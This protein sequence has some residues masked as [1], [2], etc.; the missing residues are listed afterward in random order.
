METIRTFSKK[1]RKNMTDEEKTLWFHLRAKRFS[2]FKFRRQIPIN[3]YI[4]DFICFSKKLII[5][6]DGSQHI[7][8]SN[9]FNDKVRDE[10]FKSQGYEILRFYNNQINNKL[11][12]ILIK[13]FNQLNSPLPYP[14][15]QWA[16]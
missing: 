8:E 9:R 7:D 15:P 3:K 11:E 1:L 10:F 5:E 12:D 16:R 13:I 6:L 4:V 2:G 14:L